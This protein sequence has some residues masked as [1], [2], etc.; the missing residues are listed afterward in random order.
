[1]PV[2]PAQ[3]MRIASRRAKV[4]HLK[5]T[6]PNLSDYDIAAMLGMD[7]TSG[8]VT[9][10]ND[11]RAI[12]ED[13]K[14]LAADDIDEVKAVQLAKLDKMEEELWKAWEKSKHDAVMIF[15]SGKKKRNPKGKMTVDS[16]DASEQRKGQ[17]GDPRIME[18]ICWCWDRK[19][20]L[21]GIKV[22]TKDGLTSTPPVVQFRFVC[23][24]PVK[25]EP[26]LVELRPPEGSDNGQA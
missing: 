18:R 23:P 7:R 16:E 11:R 2:S 21:F 26:K 12:M 1:M 9:I 20:E 8:H 10:L 13:W 3:Q 15:Q 22:D 4:A 6:Q 19:C 14:R 17:Y 24:E 25:Q 5:L